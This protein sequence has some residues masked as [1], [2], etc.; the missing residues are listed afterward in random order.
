MPKESDDYANQEYTDEQIFES[1]KSQKV[2]IFSLFML[3]DE[4]SKNK[5]SSYI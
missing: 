1:S 3:I 2:N 5:R 4:N